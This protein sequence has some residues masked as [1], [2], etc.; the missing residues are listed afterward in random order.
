MAIMQSRR[1][2]VTNAAVAGAAGFGAFGA[3]GRGGGGTR[4]PPSRRR[5]SSTIRLEKYPVTCIAP[6]YAVEELLRAEGFT[7][8]QICTCGSA[9]QIC[10]ANAC[11]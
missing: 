6:Q 8:I 9:L 11:A 4:S 10:V 5:K 2:F 3:V 7:E 1:R